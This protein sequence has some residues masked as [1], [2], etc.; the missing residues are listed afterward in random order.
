[1]KS[2]PGR[3]IRQ[4]LGRTLVINKQPESLARAPLPR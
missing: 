1:M 3:D 4:A 2:N